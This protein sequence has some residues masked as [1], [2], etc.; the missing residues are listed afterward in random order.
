MP[1][2]LLVFGLDTTNGLPWIV[3]ATGAALVG[4]SFAALGDVAL[5]YSMDC[6]AAVSEL[7]VNQH[8]RSLL[9]LLT[10]RRGLLRCRRVFPQQKFDCRSGGFV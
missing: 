5:T 4:F 7:P 8:P 3:P 9:I 6:Y 2:P 10:G 1:A